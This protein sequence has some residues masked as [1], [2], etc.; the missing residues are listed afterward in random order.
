M[1]ENDDSGREV[2]CFK[3]IQDWKTPV[4]DEEKDG[5]V[6]MKTFKVRKIY[7]G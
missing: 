5:S 6:K 1:A 3:T 7:A 4:L 2:F